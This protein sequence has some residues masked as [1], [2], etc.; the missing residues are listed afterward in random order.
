MRKLASVIALAL[1]AA[2][3]PAM[4]EEPGE[5]GRILSY[6]RSNSDGS[7]AETV[8][9]YRA[10]PDRL[11]VAKMREKCTNAAFVTAQLDLEKEQ[12]VRLTGGRLLPGAA[13]RDFALLSWDAATRTIDAKVTLPQGE[14]RQSVAVADEPWHLYDFDLA[15]L[16]ARGA[17]SKENFSFGLALVW[18]GED[19]ADFL[20]YLGRA[21]ARFAGE[22][23]F[24]GRQAL[25]FEVGGPALGEKGGP[26]WIDAAEGH[27][28]GADWA[29]PTMPNIRISAC[30]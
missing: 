23:A 7:E 2:P 22:E 28:L 6:L 11:E 9:V 26:L 18:L 17:A 20:R 8:H 29:C 19:P 15:S 21:D 25:R 3:A 10:A 14:L 1:V 5:V 27:V 24:E 16:A 4:A 12:A 30:G 13:H